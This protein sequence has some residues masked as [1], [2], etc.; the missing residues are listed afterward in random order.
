[1]ISGARVT[2]RGRL[3]FTASFTARANGRSIRVAVRA[4]GRTRTYYPVVRNGRIRF[5]R[6]L[7]RAPAGTRRVTVTLTFRGSSTVAPTSTTIRL[8]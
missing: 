2:R 5:D 6:Q 7:I 8:R 4:R 1:M 3:R